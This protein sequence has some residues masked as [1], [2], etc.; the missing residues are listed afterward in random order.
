MDSLSDVGMF[1][2]TEDDLVDTLTEDVM[3]GTLISIPCIVLLAAAE[4][5]VVVLIGGT[6]VAVL[7]LEV[8]TAC[9]VVTILD[10]EGEG[11]PLIKKD[12]INNL[13]HNARFIQ[14]CINYHIHT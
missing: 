14:F 10:I 13:N 3:L 4:I 6:I 5:L 12:N 9:F 2:T 1:V 8:L 11:N 7:A